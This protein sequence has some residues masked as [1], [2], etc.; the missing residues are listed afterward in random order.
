MK[1]TRDLSRVSLPGSG[2]GESAARTTINHVAAA[3]GVSIKTVSRVL[4]GEASVTVETRDRVNAAMTALNYTPNIS[5]RRLAG[6][7]SY[8]LGILFDNPVADYVTNLQPGA[9]EQ[10]RQAGYHVL[11]DW[12]DSEA[13]DFDRRLQAAL[14]NVRTDGII[15]SPPLCDNPLV[16]EALD[17]QEIPYVRIAPYRSIDRGPYINIDDAGAAFEMTNLLIELGH[18]RIAFIKGHPDHGATHLRYGG[19]TAARRARH[20]PPHQDQEVPGHF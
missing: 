9:M 5:A 14:A 6:A 3:A 7:R 16:L 4:N 13:Q 2:E 11:V 8:L 20:L 15:L 19:Y 12:L 17:A 1:A 10:C 18:K